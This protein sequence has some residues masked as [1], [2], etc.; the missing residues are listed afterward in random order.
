MKNTKPLKEF[1][2]EALEDGERKDY[3]NASTLHYQW[4]S[5]KHPGGNST[6]IY[7]AMYK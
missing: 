7:R 1:L 4:V 5:S 3:K 2:E 6:Q